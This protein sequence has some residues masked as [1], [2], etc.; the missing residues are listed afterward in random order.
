M[1]FDLNEFF[2]GITL[3]APS[4]PM[5]DCPIVR[6]NPIHE[7]FSRDYTTT[8]PLFGSLRTLAIFGNAISGWANCRNVNPK[9]GDADEWL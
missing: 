9:G 2:A 3:R 8:L 4:L 6:R 5:L 1:T 7:T